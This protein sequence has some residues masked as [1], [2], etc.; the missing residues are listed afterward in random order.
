MSYDKIKNKSKKLIIFIL[1]LTIILSCSFCLTACNGSNDEWCYESNFKYGIGSFGSVLSKYK[2]TSESVTIPCKIGAVKIIAMSGSIFADTNVKTVRFN[3]KCTFCLI[4]N[5]Q[6]LT[7]VY[8]GSNCSSGLY[9][10]YDGTN[11][12]PSRNE[13]AIRT[14][15]F[16]NCPNLTTVYVPKTCTFIPVFIKCDSLKNLYI[17]N[18]SEVYN[19]NNYFIQNYKGTKLNEM[20]A[21]ITIYV[22]RNMVSLYKSDSY[23]SAYNIKGFDDEWV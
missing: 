15:N 20:I 5:A 23:W 14:P 3:E 13:Y 18:D 7:T 12:N 17:Y 11:Y 2:G 21:Q 1:L 8:L 19:G 10:G 4:A 6:Y 22:P 16:Y 9:R